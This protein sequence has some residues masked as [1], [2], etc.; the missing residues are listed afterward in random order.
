M[1]CIPMGKH[2]P[3][4]IFMAATAML[5]TNAIQ[6]NLSQAAEAGAGEMGGTQEWST[7]QS[8]DAESTLDDA[9]KQQEVELEEDEVCI[10]IGEGENCW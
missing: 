10:P 6:P 9:A 7:E 1:N 8:I 4:A 3:V 5:A 2:T